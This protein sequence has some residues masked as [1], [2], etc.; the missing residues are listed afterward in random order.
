MCSVDKK[1]G[2]FQN[3]D[4]NTGLALNWIGTKV[5]WQ[6]VF[7]FSYLKYGIA[8]LQQNQFSGFDFKMKIL[9]LGSFINQQELIFNYFLLS[10]QVRQNMR[11]LYDW[12]W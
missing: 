3:H 9:F 12:A 8:N 1:L 7:N 11:S 6:F 2:L 10:L 5:S 4:Y